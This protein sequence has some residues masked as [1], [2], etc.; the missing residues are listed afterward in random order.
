MGLWEVN[1]SPGLRLAVGPSI[2][3]EQEIE[4]LSAIIHSRWISTC[5]KTPVAAEAK[6]LDC[7]FR[8]SQRGFSFTAPKS[9]LRLKIV[10]TSAA[11]TR[12]LNR[13]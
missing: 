5:D 9:L 7:L 4:L 1:P 10:E 12:V 11:R 8:Q 13:C 3:K 6:A 2:T